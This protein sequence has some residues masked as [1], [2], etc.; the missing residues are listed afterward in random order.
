LAWTAWLPTEVCTSSKVHRVGSFTGEK[1]LKQV[2]LAISRGV[3]TMAE[4]ARG[5]EAPFAACV[6]I[7]PP[8]GVSAPLAPLV[9]GIVDG[10]I[11]AFQAHGDA[12]T[13]PLPAARIA[14]LRLTT[15]AWPA[16]CWQP[17][18]PAASGRCEVRSSNSSPL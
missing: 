7:R 14:H 11:C 8:A 3:R 13:T 6:A 12:A 18:Q 2:W 17:R 1:R 16:S 4:T 15:A 10:T 9:K 5:T